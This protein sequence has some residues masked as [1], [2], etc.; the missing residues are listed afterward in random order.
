MKHRRKFKCHFILFYIRSEAAKPSHLQ[1]RLRLLIFPKDCLFLPD[2]YHS[3]KTNVFYIKQKCWIQL[4][5]QNKSHKPQLKHRS[6]ILSKS[7]KIKR[8]V[9]TNAHTSY[10]KLKFSDL[11]C[12]TSHQKNLYLSKCLLFTPL[13]IHRYF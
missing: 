11:I 2:L 10:K 8:T 5:K 4:A 6:N 7:K 13:I 9:L 1:S 12:K 3:V